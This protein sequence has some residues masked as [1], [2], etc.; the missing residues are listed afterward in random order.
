M[1]AGVGGGGAQESVL[2][3]G[4]ESRWTEV[5]HGSPRWMTATS[6]GSS[7]AKGRSS[8]QRVTCQ[9]VARALC[10]Q[11]QEGAL[12]G[13]GQ[14]RRSN[15]ARRPAASGATAEL[16]PPRGKIELSGDVGD[17]GRRR[18][19]V[20]SFSDGGPRIR[21]SVRSRELGVCQEPQANSIG[22]RMAPEVINTTIVG[23]V[24][25]TLV[26]HEIERAIG[27]TKSSIRREFRTASSDLLACLAQGSTE[28]PYFKDAL[29][30]TILSWEKWA[31]VSRRSWHN[32]GFW[33]VGPILDDIDG[34]WQTVCAMATVISLMPYGG[35]Q[36]A[37]AYI[38]RLFEC[39][40]TPEQRLLIYRLDAAISNRIDN[41]RRVITA[42]EQYLGSCDVK[43]LSDPVTNPMKIPRLRRPAL[44]SGSYY[45]ALPDEQLK[46]VPLDYVP[47]PLRYYSL[48][49]A[50][51]NLSEGSRSV[52]AI[53]LRGATRGRN[54]GLES[55]YCYY[56]GVTRGLNAQQQAAREALD[57]EWVTRGSLPGGHRA[58][59]LAE[60]MLMAGD[61][62]RAAV[63]FDI[64]SQDDSGVFRASLGD[65]P[66][67]LLLGASG[68]NH[69]GHSVEKLKATLVELLARCEAQSRNRLPTG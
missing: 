66:V 28:G 41:Y 53:V 35:N 12:L 9:A 51:R 32:R 27:E 34:S 64:S 33:R 46:N 44:I 16:S 42:C 56:I 6:Q 18:T 26:A 30:R 10:A 43:C 20:E 45:D 21:Q 38:N 52:P 13:G 24:S 61:Y 17:G 3:G 36:Q 11:G 55:I 8:L 50:K 63:F 15:W 58:F 49:I 47:S 5:G 23:R 2:L 29:R 69:Y 60:F 62:D 4:G 54:P 65:P 67:Q 59:L 14:G 1:V 48:A 22:S 25:A 57:Q 39:A 68:C 40:K 37:L 19:R 7:L 31:V